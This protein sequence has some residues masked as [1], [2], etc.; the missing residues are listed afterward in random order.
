M[1]AFICESPAVSRDVVVEDDLC[2]DHTALLLYVPG[3]RTAYEEHC[4]GATGYRVNDPAC[5]HW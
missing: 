2:E 5:Y 1:H 4:N 3:D